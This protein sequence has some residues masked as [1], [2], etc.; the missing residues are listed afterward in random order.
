MTASDAKG[1]PRPRYSPTPLQ[2]QMLAEFVSG[3]SRSKIVGVHAPPISPYSDWHTSDLVA[4]RKT[5]SNPDTARGPKGG[6]PLFAVTPSTHVMTPSG[7]VADRGSLGDAKGRDWFIRRVSD[8]KYFVRL[9]LSGHVHRN[10]IYVVKRPTTPIEIVHPKDPS[11]R[12]R[13]EN[14]L[15]MGTPS[16][17]H[18][19]PLYITTTSAGPRGS[20]EK[21]PLTQEERKHGGTTTDPGFTRLAIGTD[22]TVKDIMFRGGQ[23]S[24]ERAPQPKPAQREMAVGI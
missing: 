14:A 12:I 21:R 1:T 3:P 4:S 5:Y 17:K 10:G 7:M 22:G 24:A 18:Q 13:V 16:Q 8:P 2:R 19:G 23:A 11:R 15:L 6:H 9:V 20:F